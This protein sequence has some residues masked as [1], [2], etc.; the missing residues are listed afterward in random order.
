MTQMR[1]DKRKLELL[2][3]QTP[4]RADAFLRALATEM[5]SDVVSSFGSSPSGNVYRRGGITHVASQP[6]YPPNVD[7]GALRASIRWS[8]AGRL[9]ILIHDAVEYGVY[10]ELGTSSMAARPF[11]A[12][13]FAAWRSRVGSFAR[14]WGLFN[15]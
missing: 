11:M 2:I 4:E 9:R 13:V 6:G 3:R 8:P 14:S 12:P 5:T 10:L 1:L 15:V 7:T